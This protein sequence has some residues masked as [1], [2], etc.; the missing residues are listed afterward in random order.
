MRLVLFFSIVWLTA[1]TSQP[2]VI[3][4]TCLAAGKQRLAGQFALH[5]EQEQTSHRLLVVT[6]WREQTL[7]FVG[8]NAV[9]AKLFSG[10]LENNRVMAEVAR[11]YRGPDVE[12]LLWGLLLHQ[13]REQLP[14]CW[15]SGRFQLAPMEPPGLRRGSQ[16]V[17][18]SHTPVQFQL[19]S[20]NI[21]VEVKEL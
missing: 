2:R 21:T 13:L 16:L 14:Q 12:I 9:G 5:V 3:E 15:R 8:F 6:Q 17:F 4:S 1:C 11:F 18:T 20:K 10:H 7:Q 19:P